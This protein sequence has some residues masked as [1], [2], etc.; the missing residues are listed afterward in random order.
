[1]S[2][3][4]LT[5]E[6]HR[7]KI[8]ELLNNMNQARMDVWISTGILAGVLDGPTIERV[9]NEE[10]HCRSHEVTEFWLGVCTCAGPHQWSPN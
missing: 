5:E 8:I 3:F 7:A 1:M 6:Q 9:L 10:L 2:E 4:R